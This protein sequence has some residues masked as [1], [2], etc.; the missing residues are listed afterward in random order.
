MGNF[1]FGKRLA[2]SHIKG[3]PFLLK[4][5]PGATDP[6][7]SE[8]VFSGKLE[9]VTGKDVIIDLQTYDVNKNRRVAGGDKIVAY[10]SS[11]PHALEIKTSVECKSKYLDEGL[12][13]LMCP[14]MSTAG[15]FQLD[16]NLANIRGVLTPIRSN[17][18]DVV[19]HPG[20][21]TPET[22]EVSS[23]GVEVDIGMGQKVVQFN[24]HVGLFGSFVVSP[25]F[26]MPIRI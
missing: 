1:A 21:A 2:L 16:V 17:P 26:D 13:S 11:S 12:Y 20:H 18:F 10:L 15:K 7:Q 5:E 3:S 4:V 25:S 19:I 22:T 9:Q 8:L 23:G 14:A 6:R 24:S